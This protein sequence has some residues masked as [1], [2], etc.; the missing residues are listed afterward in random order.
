MTKKICANCGQE[1]YEL[2]HIV[3]LA[4]GGYDISTNTVWLCSECHGK[5]HQWGK[6]RRGTPQWKELQKIGIEK[7]KVEGR[8]S[9]AVVEFLI[10][11]IQLEEY[12][13]NY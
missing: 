6:S 3:P 10:Q 4:L 11:P 12:N 7:A 8:I 2:H 13:F 9:S 5:I 1:A